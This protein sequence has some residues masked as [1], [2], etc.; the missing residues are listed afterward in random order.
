MAKRENVH[1]HIYAF[2]DLKM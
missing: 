1:L 2:R